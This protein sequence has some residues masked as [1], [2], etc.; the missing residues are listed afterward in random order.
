MYARVA[1]FED[2]D[3]AELQA[4]LAAISA[5][6]GPP[7]GVDSHHITVYATGTGKVIVVGAFETREAMERGDEV[8]N[9]M[10]PPAGSMGRRVSVDLTEVM[11]DREPSAR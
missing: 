3:P 2:S 1:T 11:L 7:P 10:S 8:L 9:A 5:S 6:D 4:A